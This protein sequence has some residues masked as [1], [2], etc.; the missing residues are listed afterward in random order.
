M[1]G[2]RRIAASLALCSLQ[3]Y[4]WDRHFV[5]SMAALARDKDYGEPQRAHLLRLAHKYRRQLPATILELG[6]ELAESAAEARMARGESP[7]ADF[8]KPARR[9]LR[10][11]LKVREAQSLP[12]FDYASGRPT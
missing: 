12:L 9:A 10:K 4:S 8:A 1:N 2:Y 6:L 3:A 5:R 7:F 11:E